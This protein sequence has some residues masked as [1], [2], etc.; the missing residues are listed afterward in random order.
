MNRSTLWTVF[1]NPRNMKKAFPLLLAAMAFLAASCGPASNGS[2]LA[3]KADKCIH[4]GN[5]SDTTEM[6]LDQR[7]DYADCIESWQKD[8]NSYQLKYKDDCAAMGLFESAF[9][10]ILLT[11]DSTYN[12][13]LIRLVLSLS[14]PDK[15][16]AGVE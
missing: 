1:F 9:D 10:S 3:R 2:S 16:R 4:L 13:D 8:F 11:L 14:D 12:P 5:V 15:I 6:T 7:D